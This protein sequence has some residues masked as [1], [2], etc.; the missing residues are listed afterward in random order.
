MALSEHYIYINPWSLFLNFLN[1]KVARTIALI[2]LDMGL[3]W[4]K[5][6]SKLDCRANTLT[7]KKQQNECFEE[8]HCV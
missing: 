3:G 7:A 6:V 5:R 2:L 4:V 8:I 1:Y